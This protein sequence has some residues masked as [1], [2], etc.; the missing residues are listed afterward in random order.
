V[1]N[2]E[3][4][5]VLVVRDGRLALI[6]RHLG[7]IQY[8]VIPGGGIERGETIRQAAQRE[9]EEELGTAVTLGQ[10]RVLIDYRE[11][12]G[13]YQRQW[14]FDATVATDDITIIGPETR[15]EPDRGTF[16]AVWVDLDHLDTEA[17]LPSAVAAVVV[18]N[19]GEWSDGLVHIDE[20][21]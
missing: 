4:A 17:V 14:Y 7:P 15:L 18:R 11:H 3:R 1:D 12:D 6:E 13:S 21:A 16:K 5:G 20:R 2:P 19:R 10:P 9:A 8:W